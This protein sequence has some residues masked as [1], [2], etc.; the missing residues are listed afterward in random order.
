MSE[1]KAK[2][3]ADPGPW[4]PRLASEAGCVALP[5]PT[6]ARSCDWQ[7][8]RGKRFWTSKKAKTPKWEEVTKGAVERT[9]TWEEHGDE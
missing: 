2:Q 1:L 4:V 7:M 5:G 6:L 9:G 8:G 3:R